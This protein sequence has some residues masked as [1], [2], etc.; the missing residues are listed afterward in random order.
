MTTAYAPIPAP[1]SPVPYAGSA[2]C[3]YPPRETPVVRH[4]RRRL[5]FL[6]H[7]RQVRAW[8][9]RR[10]V[11]FRQADGPLGNVWRFRR[12]FGF[13]RLVLG[14]GHLSY[15]PDWRRH[16]AGGTWVK[17]YDHVQLLEVLGRY[18]LSVEA[19]SCPHS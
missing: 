13:A 6:A 1:A 7:V 9:R 16:G 8:C 2:L 19:S 4:R 17:V 10:G 3:P 12:P 11:D 18:W 14:R 15:N 5:F